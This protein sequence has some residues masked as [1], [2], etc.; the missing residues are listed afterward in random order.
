M[1]AQCFDGDRCTYRAQGNAC[2]IS[3]LEVML[4]ARSPR[5]SLALV[6]LAATLVLGLLLVWLGTRTA[7]AIRLPF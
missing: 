1:N 5:S 2:V 7:A 3:L 4:L 6:Y